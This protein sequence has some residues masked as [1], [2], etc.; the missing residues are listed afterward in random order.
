MNIES[1]TLT[2]KRWFQKTYG[3]TYHT[4]VLQYVKDGKPIVLRSGIHYG[5]GEQYNQTALDLFCA[6]ENIE[7]PS[8]QHGNKKY[9]YFSQFC[10][11][12][13]IVFFNNCYD[14]KRQRELDK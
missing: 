7:N 8:N 6:Q 10:R 9:Y 1:V 4:V 12:N 11:E 5:Y 3:N 14:V 2:A 13:N